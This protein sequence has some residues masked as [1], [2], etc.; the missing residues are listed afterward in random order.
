MD[1]ALTVDPTFPDDLKARGLLYLELECF[2]AAQS[3][4]ER[5]LALETDAPDAGR[6]KTL[7]SRARG[8]IRKLN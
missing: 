8:Q 6:I 4:L 5:Y 2:H 3:D 1:L 7:L